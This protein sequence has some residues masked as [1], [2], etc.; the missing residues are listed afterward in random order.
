MGIE[1]VAGERLAAGGP[2][3]EERQLAVGGG[4]LGQVVVDAQR[5]LAELVHEVFGHRAAGVGGDVLERGGVGGG[6]VDDDGVVHRA[7]LLEALVDA[8]DRRV[9]LAD[10]D[11]DADHILAALID[12]RVDGDGSLAGL[13]VADDEFALAATDRRHGVDGLDAGLH[14]DVDRLPAGDAGRG[15]FDGAECRRDDVALAVARP[16]ERIDD[17]AQERFADGHLEQRARG[18][19]LVALLDLLVFAEDDDADGVLFEVE[20]QPLD[21]G[22]REVEHLARHGGGQAVDAGDAVAHLQNP[23]DF[24]RVEA[25]FGPADFTLED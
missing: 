21:V 22:A 16:A 7:G 2:T 19:D 1:D 6:G 5:L 3:H 24:S 25:G 11:V 17:P 9:L 13:A 20:R 23:A 12:D 14:R 8:G 10:G 18:T 15:R 4:L